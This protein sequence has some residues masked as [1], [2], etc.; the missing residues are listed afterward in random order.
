MI[1]DKKTEISDVFNEFHSIINNIVGV[2]FDSTAGFKH[3]LTD[4]DKH[5]ESM[6]KSLQTTHPQLANAKYLDSTW[7][8][9]GSGDP[10]KNEAVQY[11]QTTQAE[12]RQRNLDTGRNYEFIGNMCLITI[13][14]YWE[15]YFRVNI[16]KI[17]NTNKKNIKSDL[18]GDL[19]YIRNSII[20]HRAIA[21]PDVSKCK[22]LKWFKPNDK[23]F[24]DKEKIIE[25]LNNMKTFNFYVKSLQ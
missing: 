18:F 17:L 7:Y 6:L 21:K 19:R 20:H 2:Y 23:I 10:N 3:L 12:F 4:F 14:Q 9:Y 11:H 16:S 25:L 5:R 22:I 24:I 8:M 13:Y 15:D 1:E